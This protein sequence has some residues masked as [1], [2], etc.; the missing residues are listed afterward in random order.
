MS[1]NTVC[2]GMFSLIVQIKTHTCE[3][4]QDIH[5][6]NTHLFRINY[7]KGIE[8][9]SQNTRFRRKE[10]SILALPIY[11]ADEETDN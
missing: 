7:M 3:K 4:L 9:G 11:C 2:R 1:L 5:F 8:P 6:F 10:I